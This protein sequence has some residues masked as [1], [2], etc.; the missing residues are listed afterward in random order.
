MTE[1]LLGVATSAALIICALCALD[2]Y[3]MEKDH[4]RRVAR[5]KRRNTTPRRMKKYD[6]DVTAPTYSNFNKYGHIVQGIKPR[7]R[8]SNKKTFPALKMKRQLQTEGLARCVR[9]NGD[10]R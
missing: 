5:W 8:R 6:Y 9:I 2:W 1:Y 10:W 4:K 7:Q 3:F